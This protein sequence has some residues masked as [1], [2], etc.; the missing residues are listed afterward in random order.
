MV[1][2]ATTGFRGI[3][4]EIE[5]CTKLL[6]H[7]ATRYS[8]PINEGFVKMR[9]KEWDMYSCDKNVTEDSMKEA[10]THQR[11]TEATNHTVTKVL[12]SNKCR[13]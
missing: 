2:K 6:P 13:S 8:V 11:T 4:L 3:F 1:R 7:H 9:T 12:G 10:E 5:A